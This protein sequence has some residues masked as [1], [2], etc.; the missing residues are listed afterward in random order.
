M[1]G[2]WLPSRRVTEQQKWDT[3]STRRIPQSSSTSQH[4]LPALRSSFVGR[5]RE[6]PEIRGALSATRLLTLTGVGGSGKTRLALEVA[7]DLVETYPDGVWLVELAPLSEEKLV[8]K[9]MAE[10]LEVAERPAEP[11]IDTLVEVIRPKNLLVVL[12]N[13]EHLLG[14]VARLVDKVL[15]SC[16]LLRV[17]AT[18]REALGVEGEMRWPVPPLSAPDPRHTRSSEE[19]EGYE[20]VRLFLERAKGRD[21]SFSL[22][23]HNALAVA[24]ICRKL[25][26]IPL[27]IELAAARVGTLSVEQISRRLTDSL[28]FLTGG[29]KTQMPKQRTLRDTLDW[30]H[31]LLSE[32]EKKLF[33]RLSVFAGGWT[34]EASEAV[35]AG[36]GVEQSA[37][38]DVLSGLAEKSL[39][40]A[41]S[42]GEGG[43][44]RYRLLEPIR[45]YAQEKL[46]EGG[47]GEEVRRRHAAFFLALAEEAQPRLRT[48][49]D[50]QLL[51]RLES[52]HDNLRAALSW[53]L[54]RGE[55]EL[56]LR[57]AGALR[58]YWEAH[59][60][61]GEGR[62]WLEEALAKDDR[63]SVAASVRALETVGW[64]TL[65]Q[66]DLD[67]AEAVAQEGIELI[68]EVR[69]ESSLAASFR[70]MLGFAATLRGDYEQAQE[71]LE[72]SLRLSREAD[73]K[74][75][76]ADA[77]LF[78]GATSVD[79]GDHERAK[80]LW[81][82]GLVVCQELGYTYPLPSFLTSLGYTSLLEGDY[83]RGAALN[84]EAAALLRER[85]FKGGSQWVLDN[86]GWAALLQ[87]DHERAETFYEESLTLCKE[88]GAKHV[89][90]KSL[91]GVACVAGIRGEAE[92]AARLFGAA[93]A[94]LEAVGHQHPPE[95]ALLREP[96]LA[97]TR[98]RLD[99]AAWQEAWAE[100]RA[101]SME[102]AIEY[103]LSAEEASTT[104]PSSAAPT[105]QLS[106]PVSEHP[107]GLTPR[108]VEVLGLVATGMTNVQVAQRLFLSPRTVQRHLNSVFHKLGV[109]SRTAATR[110]ALEHGLV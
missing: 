65:W 18:S 100:G 90:S 32:D 74:V 30:S 106:T 50:R 105:E 4:N 101:M 56:G 108:E 103:A 17:L 39:V 55:A 38:L 54:E 91:E 82:E 5:E 109:S 61:A 6:M 37:V 97:T 40:V 85:G 52:E 57:L 19:L 33:G 51:E 72:E 34:L 66:M 99:E 86:L 7:R 28:K 58:L 75:K 49:E 26:G 98:S 46:E 69:I 78:L 83:E 107:A 15:D 70:T 67:Q 47:E 71:L 42:I 53:A 48:L 2:C 88:L 104:T 43:T 92:R 10:A 21:P 29:S 96:Y 84:E 81:Q 62:R 27:A 68:A 31:E 79:Q 35:G 93:E 102:Q 59:G 16:P 9:A 13:C 77:L 11:L 64:L 36:E 20:S 80:K 87:G 24:E 95:E 23:P 94:L 8:P 1:Q 41:E 22:S 45:Q 14:A 3:L 25:E 60:H 110:F 63:A 44:V 76:I 12:D 89:T 73:D